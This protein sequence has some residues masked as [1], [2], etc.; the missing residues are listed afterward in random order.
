MIIIGLIAVIILTVII[1][2][3]IYTPKS[4]YENERIID[5]FSNANLSNE[6]IEKR[7]EEISK[8]Y[9][10]SKMTNCRRKLMQNLDMSFNSL[11]NN[12]KF[13][14]LELENKRN[15]AL[16]AEWLL[17]N[18]Y[19]IEKEYKDIKHNM[20]KSYYENLPA[21]DK[22]LM[23]GYPRIYA[24]AQEM[25][26]CSS[27]IVDSQLIDRFIIGYQKNRLLSSGEIWALPIMIRIA[28]LQYISSISD[29]IIYAQNEKNRGD[30]IADSLIHAYANGDLED[31]IKALSKE[32]ICFS[33]HSIERILKILRDSGVE[34]A[35]IYT[36]IDEKLESQETNSEEMIANEHQVVG[37]YQIH[38]GN[39]ITSIREI[40]GI[41]WKEKFEKLS[42]LEKILNTDPSGV[43]TDMD[44]ETRDYYRHCIEKL[45]KRYQVSEIYTAK[46]A[47]ECA[48]EDKSN[49]NFK[50]HIGYYLIDDGVNF[51]KIKLGIEDTGFNLLRTQF[52]KHSVKYYIAINVIGTILLSFA[53]DTY[54]YL[55]DNYE[56]SWQYF[57]AFGALL[58]PCSE[59][60]SS[61]LNWSINHLTEP[62]FI[63]KMEFKDGIP[64]ECKTIVVVPT[65]LTSEKKVIDI[66]NN[67]EVYYMGNRD[68]NLY[69]AVLGDFGDSSLEYEEKDSELINCALK[70]IRLLNEKYNKGQQDKFYFFNRYR[71][72]N[73]KQRKW[74]GWERK[75]GKLM[76]FNALL[77]GEKNTSYNTIS[78]SINCL[79]DTK[80]VITLDSDTMLPRENSKRLIGA[81][82]HILNTP[83][84]SKD[85]KNILRGHGLMQPRVNISVTNAGKTLFSKIF[86]GETGIDIYTRAVSDVYQDLFDEGIY[87]G[88]GIYDI[89]IFS[90]ILNNRIPENI[91]LSHDLLEGCMVRAALVTDIELID[92]YPA[93]YLA[94]CSR[95]HRWI[96]GDWQIIFWLFKSN[97]NALSKWKIFDNLRRSLLAP[98]LM[99]ITILSFTLLNDSD[100]W[101]TVAVVSLISPILFN[102]SDKVISEARGISL[103]GKIYDIKSAV[104][105]FFLIFCFI[106]YQAYISCDAIIR[107]LYRLVF[108]KKNLL[109]WETSAEAEAKCGRKPQDYIYKMWISSAVAVLIMYFAFKRSTD[110]G[111]VMLPSSIIWF[112]SPLIAYYISRG[113]KALKEELDE[114]D[115][116]YL[117]K[118]SRQTWAYFE[119]FLNEENNYLAP[120]NYQEY[121]NVGLAPR[122]SPTNMAMGL[123]CTLSAYDLG[124]IG[125]VNVEKQLNNIIESMLTLKRYEGHFYN[126]YNTKDKTPLHPM[127]I[128]TVDSGNLVGYLWTAVSALKEYENNPLINSNLSQ[129]LLDTL[130]LASGEIED[131]CETQKKYT[132]MIEQLS[133]NNFEL[134]KFKDILLEILELDP[135]ETSFWNNKLYDNA[136]KYY[137]ELAQ[138]LP[139]LDEVDIINNKN[140]ANSLFT[141][142]TKTPL[143]NV[144]IEITA[145]QSDDKVNDIKTKTSLLK[146]KQVAENIINKIECLRFKILKMADETNFSILYDNKKELFSIGYDIEKK[147]IGNCYY[148]LL[149]SEARQASFIGIAKGDI[150]QGHWF[151]LGRAIT[152][153][154]GNKGLVSWSGTMFEYLMPLLIMKNYED[155]LLDETYKNIIIGQK[156]YC[157]KRHL[158]CWGISESAFSTMDASSTYQ[159]KAFG[160]PGIGL[161]RG[162][163]NE[164]VLSPYSTILAMQLDLKGSLE[165]LKNLSREGMVGKY[166][167]YESIDYTKTRT[168]KGR[169]GIIIKCYMV[170]HQGMSLMA[171]NNVL[172]NNIFQKRFHEIPQVKATELLLQE[173]IPKTVVYENQPFKESIGIKHEK[174]NVIVRRFNTPNTTTP[175]TN[176]LS[177][178][179][180]SMMITNSGSGYS[181]VC[182]RMLYRWKEDATIDDSGMFFYIKNINS[183]DYWSATFQPCRKQGDSYEAI[184][185][186]DKAEFERNDGSLTT[187]TDITVS[188]EDNAE[189]RSISITNNGEHSRTVEVTSYCEVTLAPYLADL[190]HPAF[191]NLFVKTEFVEQPMCLLAN[192]RPRSQEDLEYYMM[193]TAVVEGEQVGNIQFETSRSKFIGRC[194]SLI[195]PAAMDSD[196][197]LKNSIGAVLDPIISLRIR[198]KI[199]KGETCKIAYSTAMG[200][201]RQEVLD[202]ASKYSSTHNIKNEFELSWTQ[203]QEEMRYFSIK[204]LQANMYQKMGS[205]I[206]FLNETYKKREAYIKSIKSGQSSLWAHGISGDLPI[207]LLLIRK[208]EDF[209]LVRQLINAHEYLMIK[210]LK[211]DLVILNLNKELY[212]QLLQEKIRELIASSSL[213]DKLNINGGVF[214]YSQNDMEEET[215]SLLTAIS[216]IVIDG[217]N[218]T[219]LSQIKEQVKLEEEKNIS[220]FKPQRYTPIK[221][222]FEKEKL[223]FFNEIGGFSEDGS[224]YIIILKNGENTPAPWINVISNG[225]FGFNVSENGMSCTWYKNSRENKITAWSNDPVID[226]ESEE[227]YIQDKIDGNSWSISP[228]PIRDKGEYIIEHGFGYS[229]FKHAANSI[230]S[231]MTVFC[232]LKENV[233][234]CTIKLKN[235]S[236]I[237]RKLRV[238]YYAK[239]VLGVVHEKTAQYIS[240]QINNEKKY[241]YANNTFSEHF[242]STVAYLSICGGEY[243]TFTGDR[244]EFMGRG[245]DIERPRALEKSKL[246]NRSGAGFDP[247]LAEDT[248]ITLK[249]G[250]EKSIII[251]LGAEDDNAKIENVIDHYSDAKKTEAELS[252]VKDYWNKLLGRIKVKT[253]DESMDILLNGWLMYQVISCRFKSRTAFYQSGGAFGFRDQLQDVMA[254]SYLD[255]TI[256]RQH[257]IYSASRQF[258]EGDVQHWWHPIVE[259][260][261]RTRFSDDLLWLPFVLIDYIKNTGDYSIL[262]ERVN[263]L[264]DELLADKE[265][266]HYKISNKS[267]V[268]GTI[269]EHCI[270]AIDKSLKY[271]KHDIPLMGSGD[272]NDGMSTVG[273]GGKGE[274]IWL[275]WFLCSILGEFKNLCN[276]KNNIKKSV[277]YQEQASF[278]KNAINK[279]AW[280]GS[281]YLRA[282][283]DDG[284]PLGS[285]QN[286]ECKIDSISQSW[287]V[288]SGS[289]TNERAK[290][291]MNAVERNLINKDKGIVQLLTPAFEKSK[292]E[293]G[294]IKGYLPGVRENGGQYTHASIWVIIA[295]A[296]LN[297]GNKACE[298]FN[299]IN[300][301]NHT[302]SYL[303]CQTYCAEPYVMTADVYTVD[304]HVGRGGW[305]WYTG[306]AGWMY[307]CGI[308]NIIGLKLIGEK[309]FM[310]K[311]CIPS[312]WENL[313]IEFKHEKCKYKIIIQ[314]GTEKGI[315]LD[316]KLLDGDIIPY[317]E[318]GEHDVT[319]IV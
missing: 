74:I 173:K 233:K 222:N 58:I 197:T 200:K 256:T 125:L 168:K 15:V 216:R 67:I 217:E 181:K 86:S 299:M 103:S 21:I 297:E 50:K 45:S 199:N 264:E 40:E 112:F 296:L 97:L 241:I 128:S 238:V 87:T 219:L 232:P 250:E 139:W 4:K 276:Y 185:S 249:K 315:R 221:F 19:L 303:E 248:A 109:E 167:F 259:S 134:I 43:Y 285:I 261:I 83:V 143:K 279:N 161:K 190:V 110:I 195:N 37:K 203:I 120:D 312:E 176:F 115:M 148:D 73:A 94:S 70:N 126:W 78:G 255:P 192:R 189:I 305:S 30:I 60:I 210:G 317:L 278:I 89:D 35:S 284:T 52:K 252:A 267:Q 160:V 226:G 113:A 247:C 131:G 141:L 127:Y 116:Q 63:P 145:L 96:R 150:N 105:Q 118:V 61:I 301:I 76:E 23:R 85:G 6:E 80:Y 10:V 271:G 133:N 71:K 265:D 198:V 289:D 29:S 119:D 274:S 291:A 202:L 111:L 188:R 225:E 135:K 9:T 157:S 186:L 100:G 102:V 309:G 201:S 290:E 22:G 99:I 300:P 54:I 129:G 11:L 220:I 59:I 68:K 311:P 26:S 149:A 254:I 151:K 136:T 211:V 283:F 159:Y 88:K 316:N 18:I 1:L 205:K 266:E 281:W 298:I 277:Y 209:D 106:P 293:P 104:K 117:R 169:K 65:L 172:N 245:G 13:I 196:S 20:P 90:S 14:S 152:T 244:R 318:S 33:S 153:I 207:I 208:D 253:P 206:V 280:N 231:E 25:V 213:R 122:T 98:S 230:V 294:Y 288:I 137:S 28:L 82:A 84:L 307:R 246:E 66:I 39:C 319:V 93:F 263:Y 140:I 57:L 56:I 138:L 8:I 239:L 53:L 31:K 182:D 51:L 132:Q 163:G 64:N 287:A 234:I 235:I 107:T 146:T 275:G 38:I 108:S 92:G 175:E 184:F 304:P 251:L 7:A 177:N 77:R 27:G 101:L 32:N 313:N 47:I 240:T 142:A 306:A 193:Q 260:G 16:A 55:G 183:N 46:K 114:Q 154:N 166:G 48:I 144:S 165:N 2:F 314:K 158:S 292:L 273:N 49:F 282:F 34:S 155:T 218:G 214:L 179:S 12:Y 262:D 41:N 124:Y 42:E 178:G 164:L 3:V 295:F 62:T 91:V 272:W 310:V 242:G 123:T 223:K 174:Q 171:L 237:E 72:F 95:N 75:R 44:F 69:F 229:T 308:E 81:M 228:K 268:M 17:D 36:W 5:E 204:P 162:L 212:L 257:I 302:K 130:K 215:I 191:S 258:L 194:R 227:L 224:K 180:Y 156:K 269:Y 121:A 24:I 236:D 79:K 170:H 286:D 270:K 187:H 243:R 147:N